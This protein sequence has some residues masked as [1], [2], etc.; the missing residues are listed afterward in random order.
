V[1]INLCC[2]ARSTVCWAAMEGLE[3][4]AFFSSGVCLGS[5]SVMAAEVLARDQASAPPWH[6]LPRAVVTRVVVV[7]EVL[8]VVELTVLG[9][10]RRERWRLAWRRVEAL[11]L[12]LVVVARRAKAPWPQPPRKLAILW[13]CCF[14]CVGVG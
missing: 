1:N 11:T 8:E 10:R 5:L 7:D 4:A 9:A 12:P 2:W 14:M 6:H 13:Q 3:A